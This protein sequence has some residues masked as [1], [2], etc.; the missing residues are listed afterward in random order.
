ME[1]ENVVQHARVSSDENN[2]IVGYPLSLF[3]KPL[4]TNGSK[5]DKNFL[6]TRKSAN[7]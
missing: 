7:Y 3:D 6:V 4:L 1:V 5:L 2:I